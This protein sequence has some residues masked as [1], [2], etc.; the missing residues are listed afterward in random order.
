MSTKQGITR[1]SK[2]RQTCSYQGWTQPIEPFS[3]C[4]WELSIQVLSLWYHLIW[5]YWVT[6]ILCIDSLQIYSLQKSS[7]ISL[8]AI[9]ILFVFSGVLLTF[10]FDVILF[11]LFFYLC[12]GCQIYK[13]TSKTNI[14]EVCLFPPKIFIVSGHIFGLLMFLS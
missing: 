7:P 6:Y 5:C 12:F 13:I 1:C 4:L 14:R 2:T 11:V 9:P 8:V 10:H 3:A